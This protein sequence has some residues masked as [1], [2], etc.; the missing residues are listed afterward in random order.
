MTEDARDALLADIAELARQATQ[1]PNT[2][3]IRLLLKILEDIAL[4]L[5]VEEKADTVVR[6]R[7]G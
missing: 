7:H 2:M 6:L 4:A 3:R 1:R 5:P